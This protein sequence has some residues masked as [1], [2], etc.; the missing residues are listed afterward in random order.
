[1]A[2]HEDSLPVLVG[3]GQ[4]TEN[5]G[6]TVTPVAPMELIHRATVLALDDTR[7]AS[8]AAMVASIDAVSVVRFF[9]DANPRFKS[10][11]GRAE[12]P[13]W[14]LLSR[15]GG[16]HKARLI[17][18]PSGG[19][20]PQR[21]V[22]QAA[23]RIAAGETQLEVIAGGEALRTQLWAQRSSTALDWAEPSSAA[24]ED[25]PTAGPGFSATELQHGMVGAI[26]GY[27]MLEQLIRKQ[28][29]RTVAEHQA[30]MGRLFARFA[31]VARDNPLATRQQGY[32]AHTIA[33]PSESNPWVMYP[34]TKLLCSNGYV[35]QAAS[36]VVCSTA[37]ARTLGIPSDR[38]VY[39]HGM[40]E[41]GAHPYLSERASMASNDVIRA[42]AN[43]ALQMAQTTVSAVDQF[44]IYSCFPAAVELL[45]GALELSTDDPRPLTTTGGLPYFG[46]PGNNY[47]THGIASM[48]AALRDRPGT[49]GLVAANG[50]ISTKHAMAVYA[51]DVPCH[52]TPE[53][54]DNSAT[55][56]AT[57]G[58]AG[59][60]VRCNQSG[61]GTGT[62]V[63]YTVSHKKGA[64]DNAIVI[65]NLASG[66]R[67]LANIAA[68]D[69][70]LSVWTREDMIGR[71]GRVQEQDGKRT[72]TL[73]A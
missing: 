54:F 32:D 70:D 71:V 19:D 57:S 28:K 5:T 23:R 8:R 66:D 44:D 67:F 2:W 55:S 65:G 31:D 37:R 47:S 29:G 13:P 60:T 1:M 64:V 39:L 18:G 22:N 61:L 11:F 25:A 69:G 72:F 43:A 21:L 10:P 4:V 63:T 6:S 9:S 36:L 12:N 27:P 52:L 48:V 20:S 46:G 24:L 3:A 58:S 49:R 34:Y 38:W 15:L 51:T 26:Y 33:T 62:V 42:V 56:P 68:G 59:P 17:Y 14:S 35:D 53:A 16:T 41:G 50:G 73:T 7:S 45:C 40:A 30:E